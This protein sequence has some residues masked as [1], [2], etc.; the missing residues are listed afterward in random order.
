MWR[1]INKRENKAVGCS[2]HSHSWKARKIKERSETSVCVCMYVLNRLCWSLQVHGLQPT[3]LLC[4]WDSP[5]KNTQAGC[6]FLLQG[7]LPYLGIELASL[8]SPALAGGV[9]TTVPHLGSP[10]FCLG[11]TQIQHSQSTASRNSLEGAPPWMPQDAVHNS[12]LS[13]KSTLKGN[14]SPCWFSRLLVTLR[15]HLLCSPSSSPSH[16]APALI[17]QGP[18]YQMIN[19]K[20]IHLK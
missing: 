16:P 7:N 17:S 20:R 4:P 14:L 2:S 13:G 3:R 8:A 10:D 5:G 18:F 1:S 6:H 11:P 15:K 19:E 9:F 12:R